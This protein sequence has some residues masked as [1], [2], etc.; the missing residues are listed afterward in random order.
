MSKS[1]N[2]VLIMDRDW[3]PR[4]DPQLL[5]PD[6]DTLTERHVAT[7]LRNLGH[8]VGIVGAGYDVAKIVNLLSEEPPDLVFNLVEQFRN[9]RRMDKNVAGLL[10][11]LALPFTGSGSDGLMLCRDKGLCQ[12]LLRPHMIR[13]PRSVEFAPKR[14]VTVSKSLN[15]PL[16]VKP[17]YEDASDGIAKSSIVRNEQELSERGAFVHDTWNQVALVEEFIA[18][19]ELYVGVLG[20]KRL[21]VFPPRELFFGSSDLDGPQIATGK[22]KSDLAYRKKWQ[23]EYGFAELTEELSERISRVSKK[24]YRLLHL[25]DYGRIDLRIDSQ[26]RIYILEVNANP[27]LA[28]GEDFAESAER[29]GVEYDELIGKIV[30]SALRRHKT[31]A[32]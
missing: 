9:D 24:V 10:E 12:Q 26:G 27:D 6:A 14:R 23:I 1:M 11:L 3:I 21:D 22:V 15:F 25:R 13:C 17:K 7:A 2:I 29:G 30:K 8:K 4:S 20:N 16:I 19:R 31:G 32:R 5:E 28:Y 18:G